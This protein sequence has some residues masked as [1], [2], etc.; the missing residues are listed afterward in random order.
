MVQL[1][2]KFEQRYE[3][4]FMA[5]EGRSQH[6]ILE[7]LQKLHGPNAMSQSSV[8]RWVNRFQKEG[9]AVQN[10][11]KSGALTK[12]LAKMEAVHQAVLCDRQSS[13]REITRQV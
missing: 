3:V 8:Q 5:K 1:R 12:R 13:I 9:D 2:V 11:P 7:T 10:K 6:Q 4:R